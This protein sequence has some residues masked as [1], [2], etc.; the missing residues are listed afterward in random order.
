MVKQS[1]DLTV[2][3]VRTGSAFLKCFERGSCLGNELFQFGKS[4][5]KSFDNMRRSLPQE[6]LIGKLT[7]GSAAF[8]F[9]LFELLG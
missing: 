1:K 4:A 9:K 6:A 3:A 8:C 7:L 5:A 2:A